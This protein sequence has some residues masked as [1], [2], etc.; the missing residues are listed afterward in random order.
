MQLCAQNR[1]GKGRG[2]MGSGPAA[3]GTARKS[4]EF[5]LAF[6]AGITQRDLADEANRRLGRVREQR[7]A[8]L[9]AEVVEGG[10]LVP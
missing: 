3:S 10:L 5:V 4:A 6:P 2:G 9:V 1:G 7:L 8:K